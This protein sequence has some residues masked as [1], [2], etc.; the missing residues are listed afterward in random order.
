MLKCSS[1]CEWTCHAGTLG[2]DVLAMVNLFVNGRT[3]ES[4]KHTEAIAHTTIAFGRVSRLMSLLLLLQPFYG[5]L[6]FVRDYL[7]EPVPER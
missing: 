6:D 4:I 2:E 1:V 3:F 7:G 5:S